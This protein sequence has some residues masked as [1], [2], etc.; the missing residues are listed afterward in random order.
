MIG[1]I[2]QLMND[3]VEK[4]SISHFKP[5]IFGSNFPSL[6]YV[7]ERCLFNPLLLPLRWEY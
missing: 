1:L 4:C 7:R 6:F 2:Y 5:I 3:S